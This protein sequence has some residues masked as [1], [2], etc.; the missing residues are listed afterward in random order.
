MAASSARQKHKITPT[1]VTPK[2]SGI[3]AAPMLCTAKGATPVTRIVPA[4]PIMKA[5]RQSVVF[6]NS[7]ELSPDED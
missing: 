6:C 2:K 7:P 5:P 3:D 1:P 4:R